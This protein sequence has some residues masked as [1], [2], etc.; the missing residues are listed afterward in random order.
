[1]ESVLSVFSREIEAHRHSHCTA[2]TAGLP[3][4]ARAGG[5]AR[6]LASGARQ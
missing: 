3:I 6:K 1:V 4:A 5:R 2:R